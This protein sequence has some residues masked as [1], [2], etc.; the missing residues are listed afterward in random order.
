MKQRHIA[1]ELALTLLLG[2]VTSIGVI[3]FAFAVHRLLGV[4]G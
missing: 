2:T 4:A 1:T 3:V